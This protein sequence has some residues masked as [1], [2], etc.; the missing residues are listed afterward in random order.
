[1][2]KKLWKMKRSEVLEFMAETIQY[3]VAHEQKTWDE[4]AEV[5]LFGLEERGMKP[6]VEKYCPVLLT[7]KHTWKSEEGV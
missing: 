5:V 3:Y 2:R 6:P 7:T 4:V 1:M